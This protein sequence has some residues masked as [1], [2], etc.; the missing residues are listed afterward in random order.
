MNW[1][2]KLVLSDPVISTKKIN[3]GKKY[4]F[5]LFLFVI[6]LDT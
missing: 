1:W 4:I 6:I 5:F 3:P 2:S